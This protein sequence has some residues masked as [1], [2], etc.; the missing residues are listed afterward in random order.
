MSRYEFKVI[1]SPKRPRKL[2]DLTKDQDK[3]CATVSDV[4][5]DMGLEG[6]EFIGAETLPFE[7]RRFAVFNRKIEKSCLV[8]RREIQPLGGVEAA[9]KPKRVARSHVVA[10]VRDGA[11]RISLSEPA[12]ASRGGE[13]RIALTKLELSDDMRVA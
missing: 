13:A 1:P 12:E 9:V 3:F 5:C 2:T 6:W 11:R 8:F 7:Y 4:M 10:Q